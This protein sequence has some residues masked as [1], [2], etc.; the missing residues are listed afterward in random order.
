MTTHEANLL[1]NS[2]T[3][4]DED[5]TDFFQ[6]DEENYDGSFFNKISYYEM[7]SFMLSQLLRDMDCESMSQ[8]IEVRF[9]LIDHKL[10]EFIFS[11][12]ASYKF[13]LN[14]KSTNHKTGKGSYKSIGMKH[15]L[16]ESYRDKL[17]EGF[18]DTPKQGFQLP[19][20]EWFMEYY[21]NDLKSILD[22]KFISEF[23]FNKNKIDQILDDANKRNYNNTHFLMLMIANWKMNM[24]NSLTTP[25]IN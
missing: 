10:V 15:L 2:N 21:G 1:L 14:S 4:L 24:K 22:K 16:V 19:V 9:P 20:L 3:S 17:P 11:L 6:F 7:R 18:M 8:S 12:P 13:N 5:L 23:G 25:N